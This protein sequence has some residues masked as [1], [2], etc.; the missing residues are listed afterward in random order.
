MSLLFAIETVKTSTKGLTSQR[1]ED[2]KAMIEKAANIDL[3]PDVER[4]TLGLVA[5]I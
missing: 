2:T 1:I 5:S 3:A 4:Q